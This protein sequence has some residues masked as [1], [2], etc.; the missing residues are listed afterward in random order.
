MRELIKKIP[1]LE[2]RYRT[3]ALVPLALLIL[4]FVLPLAPEIKIVS[5]IVLLFA[6]W[7]SVAFYWTWRKRRLNYEWFLRV[8]DESILDSFDMDPKSY[9]PRPKVYMST[10]ALFDNQPYLILPYSKIVW[11]YKEVTRYKGGF[12]SQQAVFCTVDGK[13]I[14]FACNDEEFRKLLLQYVIP[15][16]PGVM[17]GYSDENRKKYKQMQKKL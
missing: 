17:I 3:C 15:Q 12:T 16:S 8:A 5:M 6:L 9:S 4:F 13:K 1:Q 2:K 14:S 10:K 11:T 7:F